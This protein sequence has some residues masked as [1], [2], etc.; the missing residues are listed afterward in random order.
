MMNNL[1]SQPSKTL[2]NNNGSL[3]MTQNQLVKKTKESINNQLSMRKISFILKAYEDAVFSLVNISS[4][5]QPI[6]IDYPD[7]AQISIKNKKQKVNIPHEI[8]I[9]DDY[10][11]DMI[12]SSVEVPPYDIRLVIDTYYDNVVQNIFTGIHSNLMSLIYI[13][14]Y[15][16]MIKCHLSKKFTNLYKNS[17]DISIKIKNIN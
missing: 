14:F 6:I 3:R 12:K 17:K 8:N 11:I 7:I 13:Y 9:Y 10:M 16:D 1:V 2:S 5:V 4:K 15:D